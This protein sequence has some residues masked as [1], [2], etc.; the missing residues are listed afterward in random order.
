MIAFTESTF[1]DKA[2]NNH[3]IGRRKKQTGMK[4]CG[5]EEKNQLKFTIWMF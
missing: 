1:V 4:F 5:I 3:G 2:I